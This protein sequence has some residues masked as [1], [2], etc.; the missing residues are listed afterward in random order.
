MIERPLRILVVLPMYGGSLPIGMYCAQTL[1]EMGHSVRVFDS[2]KLYRAYTGLRE[3]DLSPVRV[4]GLENSF[5]KFVSQAIWSMIQEQEP[6]M[7]LALAQAPLDS[8]LLKRLRQV[9]IPSIMW[10]V[11]DYRVF[12]YWRNFAPYYDAFA[13]IQKQPFLDE[14]TAIGQKHAFY[15][16]LAAKPDLHK[17]LELSEKEKK[18]FGSDISFMGAG[19]PNRRIAFVPLAGKDFKI[20]GAEWEDAGPL[21]KNVQQEGR[22][23]SP[24]EGVK[25]YNASKININLHSSIDVNK[26]VNGG[27]FVNPR[28]FELGAIGAFQLVDHR[29]LMTELFAPDELAT[30]TNIDEFYAAIGH[31]LK[32]PEERQKFAQKAR[33]RV[34]REHTYLQRMNVLLDYMKKNFAIDSKVES[35][36]PADPE[37]DEQ[38]RK[39]IEEF[40]TSLGLSPNAD[41]E[42][43]AGRLR[44]RSGILG[45]ME[46]AILFL[47]E[48]RKQYTDRK[49]TTAN[50]S[51]RVK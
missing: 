43:V 32:H 6:Q 1:R 41:F 34:L 30:F 37:L 12:G 5:L 23:I 31:F 42:D 44:Q 45:D 51:A 27:D 19:Y 14:L 2:P 26:L 17:P 25:I 24:E 22:R 21:S 9:G 15:L 35:G 16:P 8:S 39:R 36:S 11:E 3:L 13:V 20:W 4:S 49:T 38:M 29:S 47:D 33:E 7:V 40:A 10:F 48:L 46:T 28:T 18:E 50:A